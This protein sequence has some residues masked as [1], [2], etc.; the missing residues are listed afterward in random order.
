[1]FAMVLIP[2]AFMLLE[3]GLQSGRI[4]WFLGLGTVVALQIF[5]PHVQVMYFSSLCLLLYALI[6]VVGV[7]RQDGGRPQALRLGGL[8]GLAF[9]VA[10]GLGAAQLLSTLSILD[11]VAARGVGETGYDFASSWADGL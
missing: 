4:G 2:L 5:T 6:R 7:A 10:A 8:F 1:M 3:R 9:A 11:I